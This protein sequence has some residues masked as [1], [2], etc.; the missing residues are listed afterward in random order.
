[1]DNR[2]MVTH[3]KV[4]IIPYI[5]NSHLNIPK[6]YLHKNDEIFMVQDRKTNEWGFISGG[7][8]RNE[9]FFQAAKRE[10]REE[11]SGTLKFPDNTSSVKYFDFI[12]LYRPPEFL[13]IDRFRKEIVHSNYRVFLFE[14]V[15][16]ND[17]LA[18]F[19]PNKEV[20]NIDILNNL[21][22]QDGRKVWD[23]CINAYT[24]HL[25]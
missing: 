1:M 14:F 9:T 10:L 15:Y 20:C 2:R 18:S 16:N 7:V 12:S 8:K 24:L 4:L 5:R 21:K 19:V 3:N 17:C 25:I 11:S 23:F 13:K 6:K 22:L